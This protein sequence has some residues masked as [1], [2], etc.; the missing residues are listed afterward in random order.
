MLQIHNML[1]LLADHTLIIFQYFEHVLNFEFKFILGCSKI[2]LKFND[3]FINAD[4]LIV[5]EY[6]Q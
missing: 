4:D 6:N 2:D 3:I 1:V 5:L